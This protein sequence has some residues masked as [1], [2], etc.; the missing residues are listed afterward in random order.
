[1]HSAVRITVEQSFGRFKAFQAF[2]TRWRWDL[3]N[4]QIAAHAV[5]NLLNTDFLFRP[6]RPANWVADVLHE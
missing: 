3:I 2:S 6:C 1:L 4:H 5:F